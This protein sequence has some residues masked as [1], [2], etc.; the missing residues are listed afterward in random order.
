MAELELSED[1]AGL[2]LEEYHLPVCQSDFLT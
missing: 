2:K 1:M